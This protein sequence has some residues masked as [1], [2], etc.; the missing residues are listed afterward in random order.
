MV[1]VCLTAEGKRIENCALRDVHKERMKENNKD[2]EKK[3]ATEEV[4]CKL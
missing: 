3:E 1:E 2:L 4:S